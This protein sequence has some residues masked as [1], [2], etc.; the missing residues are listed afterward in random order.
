MTCYAPFDYFIS[1]EQHKLIW[2]VFMD[3]LLPCLTRYVNREMLK[4]G[5][6]FEISVPYA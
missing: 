1:S 2:T 6:T 3:L 5:F 4:I